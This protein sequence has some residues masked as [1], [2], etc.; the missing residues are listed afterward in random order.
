MKISS[1]C[2][3]LKLTQYLT[4][5]GHH[6]SSVSALIAIIDDWLSALAVVDLEFDEVWL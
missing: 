2:F 1:M 4:V 3:L 6:R 5:N